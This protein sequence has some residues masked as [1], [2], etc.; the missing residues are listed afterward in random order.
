MGTVN[1][2][3]KYVGNRVRMRRLALG[4]SQGALGAALGVTFQQVQKYEKGTN[5]IGSS[6][7]HHI[8][9]MLQVPISFF[10]DGLSQAPRSSKSAS[11]DASLAS[12]SKF[13]A[14]S[15][16]LALVNAFRRIRNAAVRRRVVDLVKVIC[17]QR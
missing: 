8:S 16:G 6:R 17:E 1:A 11:L 15:E 5:R 12:V 3:D 13:I 14:S 10:F 2:T 9:H 4:M 7:L